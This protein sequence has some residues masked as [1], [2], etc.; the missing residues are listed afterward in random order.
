L[1]I[2]LVGP[3]CKI[4]PQPGQVKQNADARTR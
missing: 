1:E 4:A 2:A 3:G